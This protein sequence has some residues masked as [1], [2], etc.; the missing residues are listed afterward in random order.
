MVFADIPGFIS[1]SVIIGDDLRP[2]LLLSTSNEF[3]YILELTL[4]FKNL[5][6]ETTPKESS[7][8]VGT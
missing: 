5:T 3:L 4:G 2:D 8:N 1:S 6:I 7:N